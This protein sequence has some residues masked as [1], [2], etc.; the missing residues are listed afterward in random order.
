MT[1]RSDP[2]LRLVESFFRDY[3]QRVRGVSPHTTASYGDTFRLFFIFL[4]E[5]CG[6]DV[7]DL[8]VEHLTVE[9]VL[10]FLD[11]LE[12]GRGNSAATRNLRLTAVRSF[13][14]HL[15]RE[16]PARAG[17]YQ[18]VL[19]L[20]SKKTRAPTT[21][22]LEPEEVRL[23]LA[24]PDL[25]KPCE[26]R[27]H[28]LLLFLYNTG[29]RISEALGVRWSELHLV[30]PRQV[31]L[32][33]KGRK[34]RVLPLWSDTGRALRR[35]LA[36]AQPSPDAFVFCNARGQ[37]LG[38]DGAAY[39]LAKYMGRAA[40]RLPVLRRKHV[41]PHVLR[42]SCAVGLLQAGVDVSGIRDYLGHESIATTG[43]YTKSNLQMKRR[44]LDAFWRRAGLTSSK[45]PRWRPTPDLLELL[46]SLSGATPSPSGPPPG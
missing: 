46:S 11:H 4:G 12:S 18:R 41:T 31:H 5:A 38:R 35:L 45:D 23:L 43:R 19:S 17:Q 26:A 27:D 40:Q 3:L 42:H 14:R 21:S 39:I 10:A 7:A 34:D 25:R 30:R 28:A 33:G 24:Q 22:Y 36:A 29:A 9:R 2:L 13:F 44:V 32:H 1:S 15:V 6:R 37:P 8:G 16:D 20:P